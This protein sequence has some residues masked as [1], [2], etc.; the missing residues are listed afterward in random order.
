VRGSFAVEGLDLQQ[1]PNNQSKITPNYSGNLIRSQDVV[2]TG[3]DFTGLGYSGLIIQSFA[4]ATSFGYASEF[5]LGSKFPVRRMIEANS[6]LSISAFIAW[7]TNTVTGLGLYDCGSYITGTYVF[8]LQPSC[9]GN[10]A[11]TVI[12]MQN[13]YLESQSLGISVGSFIQVQLGF[14]VPLTISAQEATGFAMGS[15]A[16]IT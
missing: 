4:F 7:T 10:Q 11:P 1:V 9:A 2:L 12:T 5:Q 14:S 8:T 3:M 15:N 13:P 6:T 16:T